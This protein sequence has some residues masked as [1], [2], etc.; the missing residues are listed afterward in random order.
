MVF[1][2][3]TS[4]GKSSSG[5]Y[6]RNAVHESIPPTILFDTESGDEAVTAQVLEVE[7][8]KVC[9]LDAGS[10]IIAQCNKGEKHYSFIS[11]PPSFLNTALE[12][13]QKAGVPLDL[14]GK[15]GEK[16]EETYGTIKRINEFDA[17]NP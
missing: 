3:G 12:Q 2:L 6:I 15:R 17:L 7:K 11:V 16:L 10:I 9:G 13:S 1:S 5:I 4:F 8:N 14:T